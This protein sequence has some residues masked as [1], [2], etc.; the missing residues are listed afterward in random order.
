MYHRYIHQRSQ[1]SYTV[2]CNGAVS[3]GLNLEVFG[4]LQTEHAK[5]CAKQMR[6]LSLRAVVQ[7][8]TRVCLHAQTVVHVGNTP[9]LQT[10]VILITGKTRWPQ[11]WAPCQNKD[12]AGTGISGVYLWCTYSFEYPPCYC[13]MAVCK[14]FISVC[15]SFQDLTFALYA[16][17]HNF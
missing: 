14:T 8:F 2:P 17:N 10:T 3:H 12:G 6:S 4:F 15:F 16:Q 5:I 1:T 11:N 9:T 13:L 7:R